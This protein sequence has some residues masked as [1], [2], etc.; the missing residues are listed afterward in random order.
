MMNLARDIL[1]IKELHIKSLTHDTIVLHFLKIPKLM[2]KVV[3]I[4]KEW[5][6]LLNLMKCL[7][8]LKC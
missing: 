1:P 4:A 8:N 3:I 2:S 5:E 6:N 7:Y